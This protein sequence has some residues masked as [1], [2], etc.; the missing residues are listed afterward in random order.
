MAN[1][2]F[3]L[4][5][6]TSLMQWHRIGTLERELRLCTDY[7]RSGWNVRVLSFGKL[8]DEA[9][10]VSDGVGVVCFPHA[11]LLPLLPWLKRG[12][13]HWADVIKTNQSAQAWHYVKAARCWKKPLLLRCGYV[14]GRNLEFQ[15]GA[16]AAVAKFQSKE[17]EAFL[18]ATRV[19][20]TTPV[21]AGWVQERY[22]ADA[23]RMSVLP[24]FVD[25]DAFSPEPSCAPEAGTILSVGRLS[26]VKRFDLL[27]RAAK[28]AGAKRVTLVGDG[29]DRSKLESLAAEVGLKVNFAGRVEHEG[30][31]ALL[32]SHQMYAQVS[33]WEGHPKSLVEAMASGCPCLVTDTTG[34]REQ[35]VDGR[36]GWIAPSDEAGLAVAIQRALADTTARAT[37]GAAARAHVVSTMRYDVIRDAEERVLTMLAAQRA[38]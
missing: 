12:L 9:K 24:N 3:C 32:R 15:Q 38:A 31:P 34:L 5:P 22:G 35:L 8:A 23:D 18:G 1:L 21:L 2:L 30:L 4:T 16:T 29:P 37:L 20:V 27:I 26:G 14:A 28:R 7:A 33:S 25:T 19:Q 36:T 6:G 11:R 10:L 13:G 17:R